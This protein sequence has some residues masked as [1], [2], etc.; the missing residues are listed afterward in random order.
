[1]REK[2]EKE[3]GERKLGKRGKKKEKKDGGE[4]SIKRERRKR[5]ND[6]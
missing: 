2:E 3:G 1:M 5:K 4:R 6:T